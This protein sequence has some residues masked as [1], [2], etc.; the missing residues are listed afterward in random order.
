MHG[1]VS[2]FQ[3][4]GTDIRPDPRAMPWTALWLPLR[5][6]RQRCRYRC[7]S[8]DLLVSQWGVLLTMR[9]PRAFLESL[10]MVFIASHKSFVLTQDGGYL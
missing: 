5:G 9:N 1:D 10:S 3:G 6:D 2:P 8:V 4:S 7:Y